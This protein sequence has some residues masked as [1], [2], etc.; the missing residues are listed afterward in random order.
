MQGQYVDMPDTNHFDL[1]LTL[2][3]S[4][5]PL[6]HALSALAHRLQEKA[7]GKG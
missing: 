6:G 4:R 1:P 7:A 2:D 3:D 5:N